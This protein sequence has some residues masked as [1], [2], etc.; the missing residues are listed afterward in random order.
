MASAIQRIVALFA[1]IAAGITFVAPADASVAPHNRAWAGIA[2]ASLAGVDN[3]AATPAIQKKTPCAR[4]AER[5]HK[6]S[7]VCSK[8]IV[9]RSVN[10][11]RAKTPG[12]K[13]RAATGVPVYEHLAVAAGL[14]SASLGLVHL[15]FLQTDFAFGEIFARTGRLRI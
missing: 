2:V 3:V 6:P 13:P 8:S 12:L 7:P 14:T 5:S 9:L 4:K 10:R 1:L 11:T 15:T